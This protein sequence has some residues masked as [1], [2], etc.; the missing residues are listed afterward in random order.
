MGSSFIITETMLEKK[1]NELM[2]EF[3][4]NIHDEDMLAFEEIKSQRKFYDENVIKIYCK[5]I[6]KDLNLRGHKIYKCDLDELDK[7]GDLS[8]LG[9]DV[10]KKCRLS[11]YE[12]INTIKNKIIIKNIEIELVYDFLSEMDKKLNLDSC[13]EFEVNEDLFCLKKAFL[14]AYDLF[15]H[16]GYNLK[17]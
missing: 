15:Y 2:L 13:L 11:D 6:D 4:E 17:D 10:K 9:D 12:I 3:Y 1:G 5:M 8:K 16:S 7:L 14:K